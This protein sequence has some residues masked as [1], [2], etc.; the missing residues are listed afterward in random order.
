[1]GTQHPENGEGIQ[2]GPPLL[3]HDFWNGVEKVVCVIHFVPAGAG[4][5]RRNLAQTL[6]RTRKSGG[7]ME[8]SNHLTA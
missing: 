6:S 3:A 1:M 7:E 5:G 2:G 4:K 8:R